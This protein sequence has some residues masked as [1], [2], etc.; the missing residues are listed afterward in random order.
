MDCKIDQSTLQYYMILALQDFYCNY[1][2]PLV[3]EN[4]VL[5]DK[6][7]KMSKKNDERFETIRENLENM[8][9][10]INNIKK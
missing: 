1:H 6:I 7:N 9:K 4:K 2:L 5:K 8:V 10:H 3:E